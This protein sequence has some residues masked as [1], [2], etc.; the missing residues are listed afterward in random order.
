MISRNRL[1]CLTD[2]LRT[3][4][5]RWQHGL[6]LAALYALYIRVFLDPGPLVDG[7][8]RFPAFLNTRGFAQPFFARLGG[9]GEYLTAWLAQGFTQSWL[10]ALILTAVAAGLCLGLGRVLALLSGRSMPWFSLLPA[11]AILLTYNEF[12]FRLADLLGMAVATGAAAGWAVLLPRRLPVRAVAFALLAALLC[13]GVGG[14]FVLFVLLCAILEAANGAGMV[15]ALAYVVFA[16]LVPLVSGLVLPDTSVAWA[17]AHNT[18][19]DREMP[20]DQVAALGL[21]WGFMVAAVALVALRR[22]AEE[23]AGAQPAGWLQERPAVRLA[24][25]VALLLVP[26][27]ATTHSQ[28]APV[29]RVES[30]VRQGNYE[31]ALSQ[32][33][34]IHL[35]EPRVPFSHAVNLALFHCGRMTDEM[36]AYQ[37][38]PDCL[39]MGMLTGPARP[40]AAQRAI[41]LVHPV[42]CAE[43]CLELGLADQAA[44]DGAEALELHGPQPRTLKLLADVYLVKH[45]PE[46]ARRFLVDLAHSPR[47]SAWAQARLAELDQTGQVGDPQL[48]SAD[49]NQ[50]REDTGFPDISFEEQCLA[51][52]RANPRNRMAFEY[53]MNMYLLNRGL[54]PFMAHLGQ[55]RQVGFTKIPRHWQEAMVLWQA[56]TGKAI[57]V[58][59]YPIDAAVY[60]DFDRFSDLMRPLQQSGADLSTLLRTVGPEFGN[61]YFFYYVTMR[62]G[63]GRP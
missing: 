2:Y 33:R 3:P 12:G 30:L 22:R 63:E 23:S 5:W 50:L 20:L 42:D 44:R 14:I 49:R 58:S 8:L 32:A 45:Q 17:V 25:I 7:F 26:V 52:L 48:A 28:L 35:S 43:A 13:Y 4:R 40:A 29:L 39:I 27:A 1:G 56:Q 21:L 57:G 55:L 15:T 36:F 38:V 19:A 11:V 24:L 6:L 47:W 53:L 10:G 59:G 51:L 37:Q 34:R 46:A 41:R 61:T 16:A 62:S 31:A 18:P 60:S 54:D 9:P